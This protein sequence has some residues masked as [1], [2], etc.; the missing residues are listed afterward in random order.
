MH[1]PL[2][3]RGSA[4]ALN[5][6]PLIDVIL[7]SGVLV[8]AVT[9]R[10]LTILQCEGCL[11]RFGLA[12][13]PWRGRSLYT[14]TPEL[15]AAEAALGEL[16]ADEQQRVELRSLE[17]VGPE[18]E[19]LTLGSVTVPNRD[20]AGRVTGL[21]HLLQVA[22]TREGQRLAPRNGAPTGDASRMVE[23][24]RTF[25][26]DATHR[27]RIPMTLI[28]GY[29]ELLVEGAAGPLTGEQARYLAVVR[30]NI[31]ELST[32]TDELLEVMR[33]SLGGIECRPRRIDL[34]A[35]V[36]QLLRNPGPALAVN[37]RR[38][39]Y[40]LAPALPPVLGDER[41]LAEMASA[42]LRQALTR[43]APEQPVEVKLSATDEGAALLLSVTSHA[44]PLPYPASRDGRP[45]G[46]SSLK[47]ERLAALFIH[48]L[49]THHGGE[50]WTSRAGAQFTSYVK[51]P[52]VHE[53]DTALPIPEKEPGN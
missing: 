24:S 3:G 38:L 47:R 46:A 43:G 6:F 27:L 48:A 36:G 49:A 22:P 15:A 42:L 18:G 35:L 16:L 52:A 10:E 1:A 33:I 29:V 32:L 51:L 5:P 41:W 30:E 11:A 28:R 45:R 25:L 9:D 34:G 21:I 12:P 8:C 31:G 13:G 14:L 50:A 17:R 40:D 37:G 39:A 19:R 26:A 44:G 2:A 20:A 7:E 23:R 53:S 4:V